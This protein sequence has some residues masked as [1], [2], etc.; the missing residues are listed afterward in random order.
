MSCQVLGH[1]GGCDCVMR[2]TGAR[3]C[4]GGSYGVV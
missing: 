3:G 4:V 1:G 2:C